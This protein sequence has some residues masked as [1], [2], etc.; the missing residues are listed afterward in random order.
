MNDVTRTS[1]CKYILM[2][3]MPLQC[4]K[5][6][7]K[8]VISRIT[9]K[10][11]NFFSLTLF[12]SHFGQVHFQYRGRVVCFD[13]YCQLYKK[14]SVFNAGQVHFSIHGVGDLF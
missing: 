7:H 1:Y 13:L 6:R 8:C 14:K 2:A 10:C 4:L 12:T 3:L 9:V 5:D 11:N